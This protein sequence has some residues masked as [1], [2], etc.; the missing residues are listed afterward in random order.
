MANPGPATTVPPTYVGGGNPA[1][2]GT[3]Q[4]SGVVSPQNAP[5][6]QAASLYN[7]T[8]AGSIIKYQTAIIPF[9][10]PATTAAQNT[11]SGS[12][13]LQLGYHFATTSVYVVNK[14]SQHAG[15][16]T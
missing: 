6:T 2:V 15:L 8:G 14:P 11:S 16:R 9:A 13:T 3:G 5:G 10:V 4:T 1:T 7:A 12:S